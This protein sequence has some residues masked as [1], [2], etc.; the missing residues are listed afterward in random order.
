VNHDLRKVAFSQRAL[1]SKRGAFLAAS[2]FLFVWTGLLFLVRVTGP[3]DLLDYSQRAPIA[4]AL[5]AVHNGHWLIQRDLN[6]QVMA[7]PPVHTW[8][9]AL[10]SMITGEVNRWTLSLPSGL[11]MLGTAWV[12]LWA[13]NQHL[14]RR[15]GLASAVLFLGCSAV[16]KQVTLIRT[17]PLFAFC[18]AAT[19]VVAYECWLGRRSWIFFWLVAIFTTLTKG[20][21][22]ILLGAIG[23]IAAIWHQGKNFNRGTLPA[24]AIGIAL[25]LLITGGWFVLANAA[26]S[27]E[28]FE[29]IVGQELVRHA[30]HVGDHH[31]G[32]H[33]YLPLLYFLSRFVPWSPLIFLGLAQAWK[34]AFENRA[35][36]RFVRFVAFWFLGGLLIFSLAAHKRG[37][38]IFPLLPPG[39]LLAAIGIEPLLEKWPR[40][41]L[42][43]GAAAILAI[44][45]GWGA[46][47]YHLLRAKTEEVRSGIAMETMTRD[48]LER[49]GPG[50]PF[51]YCGHGTMLQLR[52]QTAFSSVP[53][54]VGARLL[55]G[56]APAFV[57][58]EDTKWIEE[59]RS[60]Q[61]N[62]F[63][64]AD[65]KA[66]LAERL[67][68]LGNVKELRRYP[69]MAA[70][71]GQFELEFE[72]VRRFEKSGNELSFWSSAP[73]GRILLRNWSASP[74][75]VSVHLHTD[76][77]Q[78][79][80][81]R[82]LAPDE[83]WEIRFSP[84][85]P[86]G[87]KTP[88]G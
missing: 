49:V 31:F 69:R 23:L 3:T 57:V 58:T 14:S 18:C 71:A 11:A 4:Y 77:R 35:R 80:E 22:G 6:G 13:G 50:F 62:I 21:L 48:F 68:I 40:Q 72:Q 54:E 2:A 61:T 8:A 43:L 36:L 83:R 53:E 26:T 84:E 12:L 60:R 7:K 1:L 32:E 39:A 45:L 47:Y 41:R 27:G 9:I 37:D 78:R 44:E 19:A 51:T 56:A 75:A 5:D 66:N 85:Q 73:D 63:L 38:L 34:P 87:Q 30:V 55:R 70:A 67:R 25:F 52:F 24:H 82:V 64:V 28:V 65:A 20:P 42:V 74:A 76:R 79:T 86:S 59:L 15:A 81:K 46:F 29:R 88:R 16:L 17:D 33:F 10:L